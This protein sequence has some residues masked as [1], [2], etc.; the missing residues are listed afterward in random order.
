MMTP[1]HFIVTA[2]LAKKQHTFK[3]PL[4]AVLIGSIAPDIP[5]Y[6]LMAGTTLYTQLLGERNFSE[7]HEWMAETLFYTSPY[8]VIPHNFL[9]APL[10]LAVGLVLLWRYRHTQNTVQRWLFWFLAAAALHTL[11]DILTHNS[12]GPLLLFPFDWSLRFASPVSYWDPA[13]FGRQFFVFELTLN[14]LLILY[15]FREQLQRRWQRFRAII[16]G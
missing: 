8:W 16:E 15:L 6:L 4:W 10:I 9:H 5:L 11:I 7:A 14:A 12:D 13:H 3:L 2:A 1:S